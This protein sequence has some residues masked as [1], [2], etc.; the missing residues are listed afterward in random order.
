[1]GYTGA[2]VEMK[3]RPQ[4]IH[5]TFETECIHCRGV[6]TV[7]NGSPDPHDCRQPERPVSLADIRAALENRT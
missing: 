4:G 6:L 1:M 5:A 7:S 3:T 2:V